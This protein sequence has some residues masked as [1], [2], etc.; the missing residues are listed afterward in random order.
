MVESHHIP[1]FETKILT[2]G[3]IETTFYG[4]ITQPEDFPDLVISDLGFSFKI[5]N[6]NGQSQVEGGIISL[7]AQRAK[8]LDLTPGTQFTALKV[9][10]SILEDFHGKLCWIQLQDDDQHAS[11]S[12][13]KH[14]YGMSNPIILDVCAGMGGWHYGGQPY[15]FQPSVSIECDPAVATMGSYNLRS[16]LVTSKRVDTSTYGEFQQWLSNGITIQAEFQDQLFWEKASCRGVCVIVA[17]L[18][19]PPWSSLAKGK[20]LQ[21]PRGSIFEDFRF[22]VH[23]FRPAIVAM[24]NVKG[25]ILHQDWDCI[26]RW[27]HEI[28]YVCSHVSVDPLHFVLP[29]HRDRASIV[30]AN[31]SHQ[32]DFHSLI[33]KPTPMPKLPVQPNPQALDVFH[34]EVPEILKDAVRISQ[35]HLDILMDPEVWPKSWKIRGPQNDPNQVDFKE[36]HISR[37]KPLPCAVA[38]YGQP[39]KIERDLLKQKGLYMCTIEDP[40]LGTRWISPCEIMIALG[41][42]KHT[43]ISRNHILAFH[44]LGNAVSPLHAMLTIARIATIYPRCVKIQPDIFQA[45]ITALSQVPRMTKSEL[46]WDESV[47]WFEDKITISQQIPFFHEGDIHTNEEP[48]EKMEFNNH[49]VLHDQDD[50]QTNPS[51]KRKSKHHNELIRDDEQPLQETLGKQRLEQMTQIDLT[52]LTPDS[53]HSDDRQVSMHSHPHSSENP[54]PHVIQ[55]A[56]HHALIPFFQVDYPH[57]QPFEH[58][59]DT[60]TN[61]PQWITGFTSR[62]DREFY[63]EPDQLVCEY[64][65][66]IYDI[67]RSWNCKLHSDTIPT[68]ETAMQWINPF[69]DQFHFHAFRLDGVLK[70]WNDPC[71]G[72]QLEVTPYKMRINIA[73][74]G[75]H[76]FHQ[77][78]CDPF[79]TVSSLCTEYPFFREHGDPHLLALER[80]SFFCID[81][82]LQFR[83]LGPLDSVARFHR[84]T[85]TLVRGMESTKGDDASKMYDTSEK[86]MIWISPIPHLRTR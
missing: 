25:L 84:P 2:D 83:R 37:N 77:I 79:D 48:V 54:E 51:K 65:I 19:C 5:L 16:T 80:T 59:K 15:G 70:T 18:P 21:D 31:R 20:G 63:T 41:F 23:V 78:Y 56:H 35:E 13:V 27:F 22:L 49:E 53:L 52:S 7:S 66:Q 76:E 33:I 64:T 9:K 58:Q 50:K 11:G 67:Q 72:N 43:M 14:P 4:E 82:P 17:S 62:G 81:H 74:S 29:M 39:D 85:W 55:F 75:S 42:P 61:T 34:L 1:I 60:Y 36:R 3:G 44:T 71:S 6:G 32:A 57:L 45:V 46:Q 69:C 47:L 30:F 40:Q 86:P 28:G 12:L 24:E 73:V 38:K 10:P 8:F 26:K 68:I